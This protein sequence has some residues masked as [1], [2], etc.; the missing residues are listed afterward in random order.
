[1]RKR[2]GVPPTPMERRR[3]SV[4]VRVA[5]S[6]VVLLAVVLRL[7]QAVDGGRVLLLAVLD[8]EHGLAAAGDAGELVRGEGGEGRHV[9]TVLCFLVFHD[10]ISCFCLSPEDHPPA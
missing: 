6:L 10:W 5:C 1:M 7:E 2:D 9:P 8:H 4:S 3:D